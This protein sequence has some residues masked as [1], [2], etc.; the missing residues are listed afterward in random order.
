MIEITEQ[1]GVLWLEGEIDLTAGDDLRSALLQQRTGP[2]ILDASNLTFMDSSG[3]KVLLQAVALRQGNGTVVLS[4]PHR[5]V[6]RLLEL[7]VPG[8]VEGLQVEG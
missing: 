2:L 7:A 1:S 3:L 8:G 5:N 4:R 6:R